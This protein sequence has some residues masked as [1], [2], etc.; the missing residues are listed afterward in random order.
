MVHNASLQEQWIDKLAGSA[1][2]G[3]SADRLPF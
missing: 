3:T 1:F 2:K